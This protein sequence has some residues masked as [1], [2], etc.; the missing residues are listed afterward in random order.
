MYLIWPCECKWCKHLGTLYCE[1]QISIQGKSAEALAAERTSA[2]EHYVLLMDISITDLSADFVS[3][4]RNCFRN[5]FFLN[6]VDQRKRK[7]NIERKAKFMD[8]EEKSMP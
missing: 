2:K 4:R 3:C 6:S 8:K 7:K 1:N 5:F